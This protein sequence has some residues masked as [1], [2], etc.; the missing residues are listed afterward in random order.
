MI[1]NFDELSPQY[2]NTPIND[3]VF[4]RSKPSWI[5]SQVAKVSL[6]ATGSIVSTVGAQG[7]LILPAGLLNVPGRTLSIVFGGYATTAGSGEGNLTISVKLGTNV[8]AT[9]AAVVLVASQTTIG[10]GGQIMVTCKAACAAGGTGALDSFGAL[11]LSSLSA[12]LS[13]PVVN[14][15]TAGTIA[16]ATQPGIDQTLSYLL[17]VTAT[18]SGSGNTFVITNLCVFSDF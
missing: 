12:T 6:T 7:S 16:P 8:I 9:S 5:Y 15:T 18:Q 11:S 1:L 4:W 13:P 17:D 14:G 3:G 2:G 10:W